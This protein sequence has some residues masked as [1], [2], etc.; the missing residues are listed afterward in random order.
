MGINI[1]ELGIEKQNN[2]SKN[3]QP[4]EEGTRLE[5]RAPGADA[6]PYLSLAASLASGLYGIKINCR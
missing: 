6:N 2:C 3:Y 5:T 4:S 1:C